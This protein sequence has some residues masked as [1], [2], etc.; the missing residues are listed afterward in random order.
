M[1][2]TPDPLLDEQRLR[3]AVRTWAQDSGRRMQQRRVALGWTQ[4]KVAELVG[5][6]FSTISKA[7]IGAIVPKDAVRLGIATALMCEVED[8]W[9]YLDRS[10]ITA[11]ARSVA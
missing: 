3:V 5:V 2:A 4:I 11:V 7:E 8:I 10:Y 6:G 9:P 1:T